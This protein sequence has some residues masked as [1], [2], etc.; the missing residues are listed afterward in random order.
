M[1]AGAN[2]RDEHLHWDMSDTSVQIHPTAIVSPAA[3]LGK[4]VKI[5]PGCIIRGDV[6]LGDD[7]ELIANVFIEGP[8]TVGARTL[9]FPGACL[10]FPP[11]DYKFKI[12]MPTAGVA[13]GEDCLIREHVTV[14]A[15]SKL[16][17]PTRVGN[18]CFLMV[19]SH[20][21]HDTVVGNNVVMVNNVLLAGHVTVQDNVT[22]GGSAA[23]HQFCRVGRLAMVSG[24]SAVSLDVPPFCIMVERNQL[25]GLNAVGLRRNGVPREDI[26]LLRKAF[27][28]ALATRL[29]RQEMLDVLEPMSKVSVFVAEL[30]EF[31]VGTKRGIAPARMDLSES[32]E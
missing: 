27:R 13:I 32:D 5:G 12:G 31:I 15:A 16:D 21:G 4:N 2:A 10:G 7:V 23:V 28:V 29:P 14:H 30:R 18:K 6:T 11:Q 22:M 20:L 8:A 9:L 26:T 17:H 24:L 3:K 19:S 1:G 25:V